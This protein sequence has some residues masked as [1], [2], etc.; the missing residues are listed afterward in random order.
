MEFSE[1]LQHD[2]T[3]LAAL[4]ARG[5]VSPAE[6]LDIALAQ[7]ARAWACE[8][9]LP[10]AHATGA[11]AAGSSARR[12]AG[13]RALPGQGRRRAGLCRGADDLRQPRDARLHPG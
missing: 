8:C 1:Y 3:A 4:V 9:R 2:A 5:E 12:T 7:N 6:L 13:R 11:G 10:A